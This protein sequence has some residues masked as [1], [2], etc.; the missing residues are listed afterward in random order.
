MAPPIQTP[1]L[2][3]GKQREICAILAIGGTRCVAAR[4]VGC[5][6]STITRTAQR[7]PDFALRLERAETD[8]E[9]FQLQNIRQASKSSWNAAAWILERRLPERY[10]KR[11]PLTIPLADLQAA[12]DGAMEFVLEALSDEEARETLQA[13]IDEYF[14][15]LAAERATKRR[16][17]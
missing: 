1:L 15:N 3:E 7:D 8:L 14:A 16:T 4:Y 5:A 13:K 6:E 11:S 12:F 9:L 17:K 10:G 2:D